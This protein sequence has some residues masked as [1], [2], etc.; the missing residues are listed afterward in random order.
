[1]LSQFNQNRSPRAH[2]SPSR[3]R[4]ND[5]DPF[6]LLLL[7]PQKRTKKIILNLRKVDRE[8]EKKINGRFWRFI[9]AEQIWY[10]SY[11]ISISLS[12]FFVTLI[13]FASQW[14]GYRVLL[15]HAMAAPPARARADYDY[16]IKLLLIGDS[17]TFLH[18]DRD[19]AFVTSNRFSLF[20]SI[21]F[22]FGLKDRGFEFLDLP[23]THDVIFSSA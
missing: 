17:G 23:F 4:S 18:S 1:M 3:S 6:P 12:C 19:T 22:T 2:R 14:I 16:L 5:P 20:L 15:I 21:W 8:E 13:V 9:S 10:F 11:P 7:L